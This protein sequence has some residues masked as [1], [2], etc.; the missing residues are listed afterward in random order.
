MKKNLFILIFLATL[1]TMLAQDI[2]GRIV[3][4]NNL[5]VEFVNVVAL[6]LPDS[7]FIAGAVSDQNGDFSISDLHSNCLLNITSVGYKRII[8]PLTSFRVGTIVLQSDSQLLNEVIVKAYR[9]V[10]K[11]TGN[12]ITANIQNS[13]LSKSG[14]ANDV[15]KHIPSVQE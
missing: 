4:E 13:V 6:S 7:A 11:L 10:Y 9:P 15:L 5:P 2:T 3:D 14:T 1:Q 12:G 8:Y